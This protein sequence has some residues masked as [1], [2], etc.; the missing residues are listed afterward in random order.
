MKNQPRKDYAKMDIAELAKREEEKKNKK[1]KIIEI[2][3]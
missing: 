2:P 3:Y 1:K